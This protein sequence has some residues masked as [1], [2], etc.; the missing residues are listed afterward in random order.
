MSSS[1][2]GPDSSPGPSLGLLLADLPEDVVRAIYGLGVVTVSDFRFL[3]K[4]SQTCYEELE[5]LVGRRL[6]APE[7]LKLAVIWTRCRGASLQAAEALGQRVA[8]ER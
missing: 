2:A 6:E 5:R 4:S 8:L 1:A 3:W 7:A